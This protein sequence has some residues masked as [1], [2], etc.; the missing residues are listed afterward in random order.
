[1]FG[2]ALAMVLCLSCPDANAPAPSRSSLLKP[3]LGL[4]DAL[5]AGT[6]AF[7]KGTPVIEAFPDWRMERVESS[8]ALRAKLLAAGV[9]SVKTLWIE[10]DLFFFKEGQPVLMVHTRV[11][12]ASNRALFAYVSSGSTS[13]VSGAPPEKMAGASA[14]AGRAALALLEACGKDRSAPALVAQQSDAHGL[15]LHPSERDKLAIPLDGYRATWKQAWAKLADL[16]PDAVR[17][18]LDDVA[19][20]ARDAAGLDL[21][22]LTADFDQKSSGALDFKLYTLRPRKD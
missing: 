8:D 21:G 15:V 11:L 2:S 13:Y 22:T 18:R 10:V 4:R 17:V 5:D 3:V 19:Y 16:K 14:W 12:T 9:A 6:A 20:V 1:M 7:L